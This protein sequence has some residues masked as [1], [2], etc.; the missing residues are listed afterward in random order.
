MPVIVQFQISFTGYDDMFSTASRS[1][2]YAVVFLKIYVFISVC[3]DN[4]FLL[5]MIMRQYLYCLIIN[6]KL[7]N[8]NL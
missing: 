2:I 3:A 4:T 8:I 6:D 7:V 1:V 5:V